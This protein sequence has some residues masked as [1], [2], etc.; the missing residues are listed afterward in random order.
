[1][2]PIVR[3]LFTPHLSDTDL[4]L[5]MGE[6]LP[7]AK[8]YSAEAHLERCFCCHARFEKMRDASLAVTEY[9]NEFTEPAPE[10]E[11]RQRELLVMRLDWLFRSVDLHPRPLQRKRILPRMTLPNM[12]PA[13][14][15]AIV[16][17]FASVFCGSIW[18]LQTKPDITSNALLIRA[19]TWDAKASG[20]VEGVVCQKVAIRMS[21]QQVYRTTYQDARNQRRPK[22]QKLSYDDEQLRGSLASAGVSWDAPLSATNYQEWHDHQRV[23]QDQIDRSGKGLLK[24][25]T[26]IPDGVVAQQTLTVREADFHP[27]QRTVVFRDRQTIEIAEVDYQ[28]LPWNRIDYGLFEESDSSQTGRGIALRPTLVPKMPARLTAEQL[29]EAELSARLV[30]NH[31]HADTGEQIL[32][33][34]NPQGVVIKGLVETE[35]RKLELRRQLHS[36]PNATV[37]IL[38]LEELKD[39][40]ESEVDV[41]SAEITSAAALASPLETY[42]IAHKRST[43]ALSDLSQQMMDSAFTLDRESRAITDLIVRLGAEEK[44]TDLA[45]ATLSDLV[46]SHRER[47]FSALEAEQRLLDQVHAGAGPRLIAAPTR[48]SEPLVSVAGR[49]LALCKELT[50]G[51]RAPL[52]SAD[53]ILADLSASVSEVRA[54]AHQTRLHL[55]NTTALSGKK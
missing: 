51:G 36:V 55:S 27:T 15:T 44:M 11:R 3:K 20:S 6:E 41:A 22:L 25:T 16:L 32:L 37:S 31:F 17:A 53:T 18:L 2:N 52:R 1:L 5:M 4:L 46:F 12:N 23:R 8:K 45:S 47:L 29:D 34:R 48:Q 26:T 42:F 50:L 49:N 38:S 7:V 35:G 39:N 28:I 10:R 43:A 30:L 24:L 19:E 14:A 40:P 9:C 33:E 13:L 54:S 21:S